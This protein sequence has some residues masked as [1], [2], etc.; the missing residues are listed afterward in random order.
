MSRAV[1]SGLKP[2]SLSNKRNSAF[3][4]QPKAEKLTMKQILLFYFALF[5]CISVFAETTEDVQI[6]SSLK[7]QFDRPNSPLKIEAVAINSDYGLASW[8]QGKKGGR[9][10]LKKNA[11]LWQIVLCGGKELMNTTTLELSGL[12]QDVAKELV[13]EMNDSEAKLSAGKRRLFDSFK[14]DQSAQDVHSTKH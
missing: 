3:G 14:V 4:R 7:V 1:H 13:K 10:L 8:R 6:R 11:E 5:V 12:P 9:A 2:A